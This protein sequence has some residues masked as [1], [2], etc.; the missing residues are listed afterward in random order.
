MQYLN[1]WPDITKLALPEPVSQNLYQQLLE[2]FDTEVEAK[3]LWEEV[4]STII[5]LNSFDSMEQLMKSDTWA[6]IAFALTYP[7]YT[8][9][10]K[11]DYQ[12]M[13]TIVNDSGS[14][15]FLV[16]PPELSTLISEKQT[17]L[18]NNV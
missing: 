5:I 2:P 15:I 10:L 3:E 17:E 8:E 13:V 12:L 16:I 11:M 14:A 18:N 9:P 6:D 1:H 4:P 7:E